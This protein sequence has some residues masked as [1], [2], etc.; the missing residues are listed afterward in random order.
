MKQNRRKFSSAFKAEVAHRSDQRN[1]NGI[2]NRAALEASGMVWFLNTKTGAMQAY[3]KLSAFF[4]KTND[5]STE[6]S[7]MARITSSEAT[8]GK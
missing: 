3:G 6:T 8:M 5:A 4:G 7:N 1:Q 2:R